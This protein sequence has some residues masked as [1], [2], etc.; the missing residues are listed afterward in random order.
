MKPEREGGRKREEE[1]EPEREKRESDIE[2]EGEE[3][4]GEETDSESCSVSVQ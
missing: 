2:P 3:K 4:G 1:T